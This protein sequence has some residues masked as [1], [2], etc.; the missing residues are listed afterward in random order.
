[1]IDVERPLLYLIEADEDPEPVAA[2]K[3]RAE[4]EPPLP[5][6]EGPGVGPPKAAKTRNQ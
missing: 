4:G 5:G 2:E 1:M 3:C 6:R